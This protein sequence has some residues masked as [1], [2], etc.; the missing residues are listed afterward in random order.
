MN[1]IRKYRPRFVVLLHSKVR[2][3]LADFLQLRL[4]ASYGRLGRWVS[5][6]P[7]EFFAV[8]FPHGN[9]ISA[10]EKVQVYHEI[11]RFAERGRKASAKRA[12]RGT[13]DAVPAR[14]SG[15]SQRRGSMSSKSKLELAAK[16]DQLIEK[17]LRRTGMESPKPKD[18]MPLLVEHGIFSTDHRGGLPLRKLLREL[19]DSG[20]LSVMKT[21]RCERK[22]KNRSWSFHLPDKRMQT[23]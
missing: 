8:P 12:F 7:S 15:L 9:A 1:D 6:V 17:W 14:R 23:L 20:Q 4:S 13:S 16:I 5:S 19:D 2:D 22:Q 18:V 3:S 11:V 10:E 21:A